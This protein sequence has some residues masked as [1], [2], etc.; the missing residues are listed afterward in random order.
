MQKGDHRTRLSP[1]LASLLVA[2]IEHPGE[3]VTRE[4]LR[5]RLWPADTFVDFE[6]GLTAVVN[7]LREA[8]GD[9]SH[10]PTFLETIPRRGYRWLVP[11]EPVGPEPGHAP[12]APAAPPSPDS[13][14]APGEQ[15]PLCLSDEDGRPGEAAAG[16][17]RWHRRARPRVAVAAALI[18]VAVAAWTWGRLPGRDPQPRLQPI[19]T[20]AVLPFESLGPEADQ[21]Y[22]GDGVTDELVMQ[23]SKA[24][25]VSVVSRTSSARLTAATKPLRE[26]AWALGADAIVRGTVVRA[27]NRLRVSAQLVDGRSDRSLWAGSYERGAEEVLALVT[28]VA[29]AV[30]SQVHGTL[31]DATGAPSD[32]I[33]PEAYDAYLRGRFLRSSRSQV[34]WSTS[35]EYLSRAINRAPR[36]ARAHAGLARAYATGAVYGFIA[37]R[38]AA[39]RA[40]AAASEALRLDD[41]LADAHVARGDV[42]LFF[43]WDWTGA[44][45]EYRRA[46]GTEPHDEHAL[47]SLAWLLSKT[48]RFDEAIDVWTRLRERDPI[49]SG[50]ATGLAATYVDAR[51]F[52]AALDVLRRQEARGVLA[53][54]A[55]AR[56]LFAVAYTGKRQCDRAIGESDRAIALLDSGDDE[57]TLV[58]A[59]WVYATCGRQDRAR[60]I[61]GRYDAPGRPV[62]PDP[63]SLGALHAALGD[64][65]RALSL[66]ER[67]VNERSPVALVLDVDL[68]LDPLRADTTFQQLAARVRQGRRGPAP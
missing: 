16:P 29:R 45:S 17:T 6:H 15:E 2:L 9:S 4:A 28:D 12:V 11:V 27:G 58:A 36:F 52:D 24:A 61:L 3:L 44:E 31:D 7:K 13:V 65:T 49:N 22:L 23:L 33:P 53:A 60:E 48:A 42:L 63:I 64:T 18:V 5:D 57:V 8:L 32:P 1:H 40:M 38:D 41:R 56:V 35:V 19:R 54:S 37:P 21:A 59:G 51:R 68:M 34:E 39:P 47:Q 66:V 43:E 46:L 10:E 55:R 30:A 67:G 26:I 20:L 50:F 14:P 25:T 62:R